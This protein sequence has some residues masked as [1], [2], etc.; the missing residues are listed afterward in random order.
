MTTPEPS[1]D[2]GQ[3]RRNKANRYAAMGRRKMAQAQEEMDQGDTVQASEKAFGAVTAAV[4]AC[5]EARGWNHYSHIRVERALE[6][7]RDEWNDP[8]L[9]LA[10]SYPK[11]LHVNFFE[12]ELSPTTVQDGIDI[13]RTLVDR[14]E[15]IRN[16]EPR[17]LPAASL[18]REQRNRLA[19]LMQP[20]GREELDD[21]P[22]LDDLPPVG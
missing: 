5:A 7:L 18:S 3:R 22:S 14:L 17:P 9:L 11:S 4:K 19:L 1:A 2:E 16:A 6:Q 21:L 13:S 8:Y 15:E 12:A 20:R 10:F